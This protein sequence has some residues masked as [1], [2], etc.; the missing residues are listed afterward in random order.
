MRRNSGES[1]SQITP[2]PS[3]MSENSIDRYE[4]PAQLERVLAS[5]TFAKAERM[6][7]FL[8]YT[9]RQTLSGDFARLKETVIGVEVF[10]RDPAYDPK[11]DPIVR[12]EARRLREKLKTYYEG[13][14]AGDPI[15]ITLP[16][17]G[18]HV[19][20]EFAYPE[21]QAK[22]LP[23]PTEEQNQP[24]AIPAHAPHRWAWQVALFGILIAVAGFLYWE[25]S[26]RTH[27][28]GPLAVRSF[29][30]L[31]GAESEPSLSPD[32]SR[33]AFVWTPP[34]LGATGNIYV[35]GVS[36]DTPVQLTHETNAALSRP[37]WSPAGDRIAYLK[38]VGARRFGVFVLDLATRKVTGGPEVEDDP[39]PIGPA[40]HL[41]WSPDGEYFLTTNQR[42]LVLLSTHNGAMAVIA[43]AAANTLGQFDGVF[44]PDGKMIVFR[45]ARSFGVDDLWLVPTAGGTARRLTNGNEPIRGHA[46][47]PDGKSIVYS[48]GRCLWRIPANGGE[49]VQITDG[50]VTA[51]RPTVARGAARL[52]FS[53]QNHISRIWR[54]RADGT[55][56]TEA[57]IASTRTDTSPHLSPD[58]Q[59]IAFRSDRSGNTEIWTADA[60]GSHLT[61]VTRLN[62]ALT[63]C[64]RWSPDGQRITFDSRPDGKSDIFTVDVKSGAIKRMTET[65]L[66]EVVPSWS[67]DGRFIYYASN[68]TGSWQIWKVPAQGG[69][70]VQVTQGGGF[71]PWASPD[72]EFIYYAKDRGGYGIWR[73]STSTGKEALFDARLEPGMWGNWQVGQHELFF[74][75]AKPPY[76]I[77]GVDL[78]SHRDRIVGELA[79]SPMAGDSGMALS[80]DGEWIYLALADPS[81]SDLFVVDHFN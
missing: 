73:V 52:V 25:S 20:F 33:V 5:D 57:V 28:A 56:A 53:S 29:T 40:I 61:R 12:I 77:H 71:A 59:H 64:P 50:T 42:D 34:E 58:G 60:D 80:P 15:R 19:D 75:E 79:R 72:G 81:A 21:S 68:A 7:R 39:F 23:A 54:R 9:V 38:Q 49:P 2:D 27:P 35:Q 63:G 70:A 1:T 3:E 36:D 31:P 67:A 22:P 16:K 30:S 18:Y 65:P 6:R 24:S 10:D 41:D 55:G 76:R 14:G 74:V 26:W 37:A 17:G 66:D 47:A 44:S 51:N 45:E 13:E 32:G 11:A 62:G 46:W 4:I 8:A 78:R 48:V 69:P 43:P